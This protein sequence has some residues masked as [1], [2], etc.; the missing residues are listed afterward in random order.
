MFDSIAQ[1]GAQFWQVQLTIPMG[2]AA[3]NANILLQPYEI[4]ETVEV[5]AELFEH[6]RKIG[7]RVLP[8]NNIGYFGPYE[9]LWRTLTS[10]P[11]FY[12]GC[13]AGETTLALEADGT[14]KGCPSLATER[15]SVGTT[16][17]VSFEKAIE[18]LAKKSA[19]RNRRRRHSFCGSCYYWSVCRG[20]CTWVADALTG[21]RGDN[22]YCYYRARELAKKGLRERVVKVAAAPGLSFDTARFEIM[23]EDRSGRS[24]PASTARD[25]K[26]RSHG[27]KLGLCRNC[28]EYF[29]LYEQRCPHCHTFYGASATFDKQVESAVRNLI[30]K[31]D[32]GSQEMYD[33]LSRDD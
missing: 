17:L 25:D 16:R 1:A 15:Y 23:V 6:G 2:N 28:H 29:F 27:R 3:D 31:I 26:R 21:K 19:R 9:Y 33:I 14:I 32:E 18:A 4:I 11:T 5:L 24:M 7:V 20:G 12:Q 22:P 13:S 10:E 30:E 8:G